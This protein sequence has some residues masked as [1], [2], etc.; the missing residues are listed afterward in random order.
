MSM[1][2]NLLLLL[3]LLVANS[4]FAQKEETIFYDDFIDNR[5]TWAIGSNESTSYELKNGKYYFESKTKGKTWSLYNSVQK[6]FDG[7]KDFKVE[8]TFQQVKGNDDYAV[9]LFCYQ[10]DELTK[11]FGIW[12]LSDGKWKILIPGDSSTQ[13][14]WQEDR[15]VKKGNEVSNTA[16]ILKI[17]NTISFIINNETV[18]QKNYAPGN[19]KKISYQ[20][21][22]EKTIAIDYVKIAYISG[23]FE[24]P[25]YSIDAKYYKNF[26]E[27]KSLYN[28]RDYD[29]AIVSFT[30][31]INLKPEIAYTYDWRGAAYQYKKEPEIDIAISDYKE[32]I[33]LNPTKA[34]LPL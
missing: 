25:S 9:G 17:G 23:E 1:K 33:K 4:L 22:N 7:N 32:A 24:V 29:R 3:S 2:N 14:D 16:S 21:G 28:K 8:W 11:G 19:I 34:L 12:L 31:A 5:N 15:V 10:D 26:E 13:T 27:G 18:F 20:I 30:E 6:P